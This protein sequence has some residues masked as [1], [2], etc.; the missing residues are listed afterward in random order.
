MNFAHD[1]RKRRVLPLGGG[2]RLAVV[3]RIEN[4]GV[5][6]V[7]RFML[8]EDNGRSTGNGQQATFEMLRSFVNP[9][10][11]VAWCW[12]RHSRA[13]SKGVWAQR[14]SEA[15]TAT[16]SNAEARENISGA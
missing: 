7:W 10:R 3:M 6:C 15:R 11:I 4:D 2:Y 1:R 12:M 14:A 13:A 16:L 5:F 8:A 9:S